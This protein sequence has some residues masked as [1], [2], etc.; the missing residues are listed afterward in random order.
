MNYK[1]R[2]LKTFLYGEKITLTISNILQER[3]FIKVSPTHLT[4]LT[5]EGNEEDIDLNSVTSIVL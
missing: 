1:Y 3:I 5:V 2:I 4:L